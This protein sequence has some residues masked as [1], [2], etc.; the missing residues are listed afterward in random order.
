MYAQKLDILFFLLK[1]QNYF[2]GVFFP[3]YVFQ[4]KGKIIS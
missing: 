4:K 3:N 2:Y 1:P